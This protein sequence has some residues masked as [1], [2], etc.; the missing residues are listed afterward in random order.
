MAS[1]SYRV[2][3]GQLTKCDTCRS[4]SI[5]SCVVFTSFVSKNSDSICCCHTNQYSLYLAALDWTAHIKTTDFHNHGCVTT[6]ARVC[7]SQ[8]SL[9]F[10]MPWVARITACSILAVIDFI[11]L[12][13]AVCSSR[14]VRSKF[15]RM[16]STWVM[17]LS[18]SC[19]A[20]VVG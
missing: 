10:F 4:E 1:Q 18:I 11:R 20:I 13:P 2:N 3:T 12:S 5:V 14:I 6:A 9:T 15:V 8:S 16:K 19:R 17:L 7:S